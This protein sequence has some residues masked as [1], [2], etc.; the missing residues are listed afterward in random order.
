MRLFFRIKKFL[1]RLK[2]LLNILN[3]EEHDETLKSQIQEPFCHFYIIFLK[4]C[5]MFFLKVQ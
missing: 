3:L 2:K 4:K 1:K 5:E